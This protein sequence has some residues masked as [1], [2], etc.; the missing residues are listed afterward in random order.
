MIKLSVGSGPKLMSHCTISGY[1]SILGPIRPPGLDHLIRN[2]DF[3][4]LP[5][6]IYFVNV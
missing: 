4:S 6:I 2:T 3:F 5:M 1:T